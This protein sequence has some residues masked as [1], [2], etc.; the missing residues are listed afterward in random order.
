MSE[1]KFHSH[2]TTGKIVALYI[3]T[4]AYLTEDEK[5]GLDGSKHCQS[6]ISCSREQWRLVVEEA[7]AHPGL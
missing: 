3:Q 1:T 5:T 2:R 4:F 7:K 6:S